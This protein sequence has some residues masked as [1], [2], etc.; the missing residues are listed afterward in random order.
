[1][2]LHV[3]DQFNVELHPQDSPSAKKIALDG[4]RYVDF[5]TLTATIPSLIPKGKYNLVITTPYGL[6][7]NLDN[8]FTSFPNDIDTDSGTDMD[9]DKDAGTDSGGEVDCEGTSVWRDTDRN[10]CW[11]N[12]H[13]ELFYYWDDADGYCDTLVLDGYDDWK[14]PNTDDLRS[15][16]RGCPNTQTGGDCLVVDGSDDSDMDEACNGCEPLSGPGDNGCYWSKELKG[17]CDVQF[18]S[19]SLPPDSG[20]SKWHISFKDGAIEN[21]YGVT[22]YVRCVRSGQ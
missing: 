17:A 6:T 22:K 3:D 19:S 18:W 13:D 8:A 1:M 15:L 21:S 5:K 11:Q 16:I 2:E 7:G 14:M 10:L 12:P 9:T 4:I 20:V